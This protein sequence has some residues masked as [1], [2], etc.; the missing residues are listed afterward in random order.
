MSY[1]VKNGKVTKTPPSSAPSENIEDLIGAHA[2]IIPDEAPGERPSRTDR[3]KSG[4]SSTWA[5][6]TRL[7]LQMAAHDDPVLVAKLEPFERNFAKLRGALQLGDCVIK[8]GGLTIL[9]G[10][11]SGEG[12]TFATVSIAS[13]IGIYLT[14][15]D[16]LSFVRGSLLENGLRA[17][18]DHRL[19][20]TFFSGNRKSAKWAKI[21]RIG[22]SVLVGAL[23]AFAVGLRYEYDAITQQEQ[24]DFIAANRVIYE[25]AVHDF[26]SVRQRAAKDYQD[27]VARQKAG[28]NSSAKRRDQIDAD[29]QAARLRLD[30]F[31]QGRPDAITRSMGAQATFVPKDDSFI[32]RV[33]AFLEVLWARPASALPIIA[34]DLATCAL[35][36]ASATISMIYVPS[37]YAAELARRQ[38]ETLV[39]T[40]R[41]AAATLRR[42]GG[43]R[44]GT[45]EGDDEPP[46]APASPA[47]SA[48]AAPPE[49]PEPP[50]P[51]GGA[52]M[53][54]KPP[55]PPAD[56]TGAPMPARRGRGRPRKDASAP[57]NG[58]GGSDV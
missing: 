15:L 19:N 53:P 28:R 52:A 43:I 2:T 58:K 32:G 23:L 49:P 31:D 34:V 55:R 56:A 14:L 13:L 4:L 37:A 42:G 16:H 26:D 25:Q 12:V 30:T 17:M 57:A 41:E 44:P 21:I 9:I 20:V 50:R 5:S 38:L 27:A 24:L 8:A 29:V 40:T 18:R 45:G 11:V 35:D 33:R 46:P 1:T 36:L 51:A 10:V 3:L 54:P 39:R 22:M 6:L 47:G 7:S 48:A